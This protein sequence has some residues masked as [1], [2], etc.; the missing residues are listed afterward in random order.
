VP[1]TTTLS[2]TTPVPSREYIE[3]IA[4]YYLARGEP[5]TAER[6]SSGTLADAIRMLERDLSATIKM[7]DTTLPGVER[8]A[9]QA[10]RELAELNARFDSLRAAAHDGVASLFAA[11]RAMPEMGAQR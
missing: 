9:D 2:N 10:V 11:L 3:Q 7:L 5:E 8:K 1:D 4:R 6:V